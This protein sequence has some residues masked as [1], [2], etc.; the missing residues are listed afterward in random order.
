MN[1]SKLLRKFYKVTLVVLKENGSKRILDQQFSLGHNII[2]FFIILLVPQLLIMSILCA[3]TLK[4]IT[5]EEYVK[6]HPT[7]CLLYEMQKPFL[8]KAYPI[9]QTVGSA[10]ESLIQLPPNFVLSIPHGGISCSEGEVITPC[11]SLLYDLATLWG[12]S[13]EEN[14]LLKQCP[15]S[16]FKYEA[17][18]A[19][20]SCLGANNY[21]H[22]MLDL[23]PKIY[24][25]EKVSIHPD[26]YYIDYNGCKFQKE[27]LETLGIDE[28]K[29]ICAS[30][31]EQLICS[32]L[33]VPSLPGRIGISPKW[34]FD[35][36]K[37]KFLLPLHEKQIKELPKKIYVSREK[38]GIRKLLN[39]S[40]LNK[41]LKAL[42]FETVFL[43][44]LSVKKQAQ[45]FYYADI[46]VAIHGAGLT[47]MVFCSDKTHIIE[48]A[49]PSAVNGCFWPISQQ[50]GIDHTVILGSQKGLSDE[51]VINQNFYLNTQAQ[52][53]LKQKLLELLRFSE[54]LD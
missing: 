43:E 18:V 25:L 52:R 32:N 15:Y 23:L 49:S 34:A 29:I 9:E 39:E 51:D 31:S 1:I 6:Y 41:L 19:N 5:A 26:L 36:L 16:S 45:L 4:L 37:R 38:A 40:K 33:V 3:T 53:I 24:L 46:I 22:W 2:L 42:G 7:E 14:P 20:V 30:T 54:K 28:S 21:Y 8:I 12:R 27:T 48:L 47:N 10:I 11:N 44:D 17:V 13:P 50:L 35:F